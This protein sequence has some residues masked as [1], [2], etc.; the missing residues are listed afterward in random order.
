MTNVEKFK[1]VFA[2]EPDIETMI[3]KCPDSTIA[4]DC[5][6]MDDDGVCHCEN[7]WSEEYRKE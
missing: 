2:I 4:N 3:P 7:W 5:K 1:E 6:Y